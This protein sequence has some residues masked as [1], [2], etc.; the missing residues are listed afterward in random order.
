MR[1]QASWACP[2]KVYFRLVAP[3]TFCSCAACSPFDF[4]KIMLGSETGPGVDSHKHLRKNEER[5]ETQAFVARAIRPCRVAIFLNIWSSIFTAAFFA[6]VKPAGSVDTEM[7]L[8][9][10][11]LFADLVGRPLARL[12]RPS[13]AST[14][15][16]LV[17]VATLR[18]VLMVLFFLYIA[19]DEWF[20]LRSDVLVVALVLVFSVLSGYLA[21]LSYEYAAA[22]LET[23]AGQAQAGTL[24]NSTF[25]YAA[26]TAVLMGVAVS[27][28]GIFSDEETNST[29][30]NGNS[31]GTEWED[32]YVKRAL[33]AIRVA[34]DVVD[35]S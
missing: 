7:V 30:S 9:F 3:Q 33:F 32:G 24:M 19:F 6:Y 12:P 13:W 31:D 22:S 5:E 21:V 11:R 1:L 2:N 18:L 20:G 23:K 17:R 16:Q 27:A 25:Q 28:M 29:G 8:Y 14:K 34:G 15:D 35:A 4:T 10:V 26:F